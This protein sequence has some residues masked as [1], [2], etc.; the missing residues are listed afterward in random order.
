[1]RKIKAKVLIDVESSFDD[2]ETDISSIEYF[3]RQDLQDKGWLVNGTK[4]KE[5]GMKE[6]NDE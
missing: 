3:I 4:V 2:N 6:E 1:M 5:F